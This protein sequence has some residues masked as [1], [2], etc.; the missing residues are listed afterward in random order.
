MDAMNDSDLGYLAYLVRIWQVR[1]RGQLVWRASV[2]NAHTGERQAFASLGRL[3]AFLEEMTGGRVRHVE[4]GQ[5]TNPS[6]LEP[7]ESEQS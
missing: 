4:S 5:N 1:S 3:F 6:N 2:E 7:P